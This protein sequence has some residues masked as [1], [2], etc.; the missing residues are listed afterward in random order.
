MYYKATVVVLLLGSVMAG[1]RQFF[2]SPINCDA[3]A[4]SKIHL[5]KISTGRYPNVLFRRV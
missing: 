1:S 2:G 5:L 3:G 4:V